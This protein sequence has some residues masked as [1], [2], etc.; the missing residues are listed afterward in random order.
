MGNN[1]K[2]LSP[3]DHAQYLFIA[4]F[5]G[6][7]LWLSERD[8]TKKLRSTKLENHR[9]VHAAPQELRRNPGLTYLI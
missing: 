1:P 8:I 5:N 7:L 2:D 6:A 3:M 9:R 4:S